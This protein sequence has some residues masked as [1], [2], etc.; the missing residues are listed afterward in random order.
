MGQGGAL[1]VSDVLQ[2]GAGRGDGQRQ[3]VDAEAAQIQRAELVGKGARGGGQ[4]VMPGRAFAHDRPAT[5]GLERAGLILAQ[6]QFRRAQPLKFGGEHR[7]PLRF[8]HR[9]AARSQFQP[10][11]SK[12]FAGR[13]VEHRSEQR[14]A[15]PI[16]Q[17]IVGHGAGRYDAHHL[18]LHRSLGFRRVAD[19]LA[20]CHR[21]AAS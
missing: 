18:A 13:V 21:F 3:L 11:Q 12:A 4:I 20:D 1:R 14:I 7:W 10:G 8:E 2:Q 17:R 19:L 9:E 16:E 6:Q 5:Q 15:A